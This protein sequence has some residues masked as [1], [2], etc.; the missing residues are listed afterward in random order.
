M[1]ETYLLQASY[2][3][4]SI[5]CFVWGWGME[6]CSVFYWPNSILLRETSLIVLASL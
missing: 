2:L 4:R 6:M 5:Q 3:S 1:V